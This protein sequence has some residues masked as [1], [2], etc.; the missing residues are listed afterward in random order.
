[1]FVHSETHPIVWVDRRVVDESSRLTAGP[2]LASDRL[3]TWNSNF[4]EVVVTPLF[5]VI[6]SEIPVAVMRR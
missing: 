6:L 5:E 3:K 2:L 4:E 1:M